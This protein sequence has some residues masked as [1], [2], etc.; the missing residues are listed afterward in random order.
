MMMVP[1]GLT[2]T[3]GR[4]GATSDNSGK[5][6]VLP[7]ACSLRIPTPRGVTVFMADTSPFTLE[8]HLGRCV[9]ATQKANVAH[10]DAE[11]TAGRH[12]QS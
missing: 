1:C 7:R 8:K 4:A 10:K 3:G 11:Q 5:R 6:I 9:S 12:E 2:L